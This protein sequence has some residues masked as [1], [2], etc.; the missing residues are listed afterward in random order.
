VLPFLIF[1]SDEGLAIVTFDAVSFLLVFSSPSDD[2]VYFYD[3][4]F[5]LSMLSTISA[6]IFYIPLPVFADVYK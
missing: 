5:D 1:N 4:N 3:L 6:T 2:F